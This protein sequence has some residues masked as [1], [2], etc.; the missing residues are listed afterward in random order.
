M[1]VYQIGDT[2]YRQDIVSGSWMEMTGYDA[3]ATERLWQEIDP[4]GCLMYQATA[5]VTELAKEKSMA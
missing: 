2:F 3:D 4:L 5:E 1:D